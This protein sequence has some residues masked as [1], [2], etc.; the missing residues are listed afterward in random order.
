[1]AR[2]TDNFPLVLAG[3]GLALWLLLHTV[4]SILFEDWLKHQLEHVA[5]HT[6]A[7][8]IERFGHLGFPALAAMAIV[9][10]VFVY[11]KASAKAELAETTTPP[12]VESLDRKTTILDPS[13]IRDALL[14]D[15]IWRAHLGQW[16]ARETYP[17][18][19]WSAKT[20]FY[21]AAN[22]IR[23]MAFEGKLPIWARRPS[24]NLFEVVPSGFWLNHDIEAGYCIIPEVTDSWVKITFPLEVGDVPHAR[25]PKWTDF[26]TSKLA[27][28]ALWPSQSS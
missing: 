19:D 14:L 5:G 7:E 1:M 6:V 15:A 26:M 11:A 27:V 12:P 16:K 17:H 4:W 21:K 3:A 13:W 28:E 20:P 8:V 25:T 9:W 2:K 10:F 24:S 22:D 18:D 23:Q